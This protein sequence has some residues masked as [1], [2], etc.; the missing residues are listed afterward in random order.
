MTGVII[1]FYLVVLVELFFKDDL[2][3]VRYLHFGYLGIFLLSA[4]LMLYFII[5]PIFLGKKH[6][7]KTLWFFPVF[8]FISIKYFSP[9]LIQSPLLT[10]TIVGPVTQEANNSIQYTFLSY[11]INHRNKSYDEVAQLLKKNPADLI[12]LQ[13]IPYSRYKQFWASIK[14]EGLSQ[15]HHVYSRK[16]SLMI[17]SKQEIIPN[18]TMPYLQATTILD[19]QA[20]KIWN[21]H[22]PKSLT[23]KN[24]QNFYF[25]KLQNDIQADLTQHKLVCGDFNSTPHNDIIS[26]LKET[27]QLQAAYEHSKTTLDFSYPT[28]NG[29]IPSPVPFLKIDY[30]LF[31]KNFNIK[32]Y[33]RIKEHANSDHYPIMATVQLQ[34]KS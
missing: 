16:K 28:I 15:Y 33:K 34:E 8:I 30:L 21:L 5:K 6:L 3:I 20:L 17:L 29:I 1:I 2:M 10:Q 9:F 12:C 27:G 4:I 11:S 7:A 32:S 22:S 25:H 19:G 31:T 24:Y 18:K 14:A 13:E 26:E 23:K